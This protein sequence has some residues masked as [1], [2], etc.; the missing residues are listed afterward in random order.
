MKETTRNFDTH[1][2]AMAID[3]EKVATDKDELRG[4]INELE[5]LNA[6]QA[7]E[8]TELR[9]INDGLRARIT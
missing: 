5:A 8:F 6:N 2:K 1:I 3:H 4:Q 7:D 9:S